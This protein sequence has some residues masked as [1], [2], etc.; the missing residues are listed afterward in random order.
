MKAKATEG[1]N[2]GFG[3]K[4]KSLLGHE[5]YWVMHRDRFLQVEFGIRSVEKKHSGKA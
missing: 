1:R 4:K 2:T 5:S 3:V